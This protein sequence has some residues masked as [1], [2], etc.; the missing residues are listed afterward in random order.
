MTKSYFWN[1]RPTKSM[2]DLQFYPRSRKNPELVTI[3]GRIACEG[4]RDVMFS[5][6]IYCK[7]S[8][9]DGEHKMILGAHREADNSFLKE[10]R[11][12]IKLLYRG[13]KVSHD[14]VTPNMVKEAF[15]ESKGGRHI[16]LF[17][18]IPQFLKRKQSEVAASTF[19]AY[20]HRIKKVEE[21]FKEIGKE[22]ILLAEITKKQGRDFVRWLD[23][24][25]K[26][27]ANYSAK[28]VELFNMLMNFAVEEGYLKN[29]QLSEVLYLKRP[30]PKEVVY[31]SDEELKVL[32]LYKF[33]SPPLQKASDIFQFLCH[34]GMS[35][36]DYKEFSYQQDVF[37]IL[38]RL[39]IKKERK[40]TGVEYKVPLN[41]KAL[42]LLEKHNY[43]LPILS[44]QRLNRY[45]K[46]VMA[47]INV[48]KPLTSHNGRK[49]FAMH[50]MLKGV[51]MYA[52]SK[53][54]G[55]RSI[56]TTETF[57]AN[58]AEITLKEEMDLILKTE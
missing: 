55:H 4:L 10:I 23:K 20:R 56:A 46:E 26:Y 52:I 57:Y 7:R 35:Y 34:T 13:L 51:T 50:Q 30:R 41:D 6:G 45:I 14:L 36:A 40:K 17:D 15:L 8:E 22:K 48:Q 27:E 9:W 24:I 31:L 49:T 11:N 43:K 42:A 1:V 47:V 33:A 54:L 25:R 38:G 5:T 16:L 32:E 37:K 28:V 21:Y 18:F 3:Y 58:I 53:M 39:T 29:N 19:K 2:V 44:V 12:E